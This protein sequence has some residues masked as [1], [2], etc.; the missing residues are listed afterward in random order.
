[1]RSELPGLLAGCRQGSTDARDYHLGDKRSPVVF[2]ALKA[3]DSMC[4][5]ETAFFLEHASDWERQVKSISKVA[6]LGMGGVHSPSL[7]AQ[8]PWRCG[9][10]TW[11]VGMV[12]WLMVGL[13][14]LNGLSNLN[15][16]MIGKNTGCGR[17][18]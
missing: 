9:T 10:G 18:V 14:D 12:G 4:A 13:D 3:E 8:E 2:K 16:S 15:D 6:A 17:N 7:G 5:S 11:L 1:M